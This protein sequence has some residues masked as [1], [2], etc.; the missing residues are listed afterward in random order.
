MLFALASELLV[1]GWVQRKF[2][3]FHFQLICSLYVFMSDKQKARKPRVF[4]TFF[5]HRRVGV[6][7]MYVD[8]FASF[9]NASANFAGDAFIFASGILFTTDTAELGSRTDGHD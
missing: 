4:T 5:L 1:F 8:R 3:F 9:S 6:V 2:H 7:G